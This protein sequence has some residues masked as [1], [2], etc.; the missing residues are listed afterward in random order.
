MIE[1]FLFFTMVELILETVL[2]FT[3]LRNRLKM[4]EY[5]VYCMANRFSTNS[6]LERIIIFC[7][8]RYALVAKKLINR[9]KEKLVTFTVSRDH[10]NK[11]RETR[12]VTYTCRYFSGHLIPIIQSCQDELARD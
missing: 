1:H 7:L 12:V 9:Y 6:C 2:R 10:S 11:S 8:K 4:S 5:E 3:T